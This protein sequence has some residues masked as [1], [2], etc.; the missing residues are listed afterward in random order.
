M[1][2]EIRWPRKN[3]DQGLPGFFSIQILNVGLDHLNQQIQNRSEQ[4]SAADYTLDCSEWS[5]LSNYTIERQ[6]G[7]QTK[8]ND[9]WRGAGLVYWG[10]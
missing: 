2:Q 1:A 9:Q 10:L 5:G 3:P 7:N 8:Y 4:K 6:H